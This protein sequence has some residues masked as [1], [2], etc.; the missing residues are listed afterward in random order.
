MKGTDYHRRLTQRGLTQAA[1]AK[2]MT[3]H[4]GRPVS[5]KAVSRILTGANKRFD[6]E[7]ANAIEQFLQIHGDNAPASA[8]AGQY[9]PP[10]STQRIPLYGFAAAA[11]DDHIAYGADSVLDW[12]EPPALNLDAAFRVA[13]SSMEPRLF[14]GETVFVRLGLRPARGNDCVVELKDESAGVLIKT[15][16][17]ASNGW[18]FLRQW[19]PDIE[20]KLR[21]DEIRALHAVR[22]RA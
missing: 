12:L 14:A 15:F 10:R 1:L 9:E 20:L 5:A 6:V 8:P 2:F 22:L 17:K 7:E 4:L 11:D 13:G 19:N 18:V 16:T 3:E 21:W